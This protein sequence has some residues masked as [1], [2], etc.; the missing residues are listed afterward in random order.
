MDNLKN[1]SLNQILTDCRQHNRTAQKRLYYRFYSYGLTVCLHYAR[2]QEEAEEILHD[3]FLKV[4]QKLDLYK[5]EGVFRSWLRSILVR[6]AIDYFRK[7]NKRDPKKLL[8]Q[9]NT[10][11]PVENDA[12]L[13]LE[14]EEVI[15]ILQQLPP[16]YRMVNKSFTGLGATTRLIK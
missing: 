8:K 15:L 14:K 11:D 4:F 7:K 1:Q 10:F 16:S 3:G 9:L 13:V 5:G 12:E 6:T 2:N